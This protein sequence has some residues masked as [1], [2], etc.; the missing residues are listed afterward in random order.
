MVDPLP[1]KYGSALT[2]SDWAGLPLRIGHVPESGTTADL[3][4]DVDTVLV[5]AGGPS[6]L[7]IVYRIETTSEPLSVQFRRNPGSMDLLPRGTHLLSIDWQGQ[8]SVCTAVNF[9]EAALTALCPTH[10]GGLDKERG[11]RFGL[12]DAHVFDLVQR[13][14]TQA[15]GPEFF[16]ALYVQSL[17]LALASYLTA[18]YGKQA[19]DETLSGKSHLS[20]EQRKKVEEFV[21]RELPCNFGLVD[22][23]SLTGYSP[24]HFSRLFKQSF[25]QSPHQYVLS[26]RIERAK[27]MLLNETQSIAEI[28]LV[29]GFASQAHMTSAFKRYTGTTPGA[30][31]K[32]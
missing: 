5:W 25:E 7:S 8:P 29:C 28:A 16:G 22:I 14:Q 26:R 23:A 12:V 24:D 20:Q 32:S 10:A 1:S 17:S 15:Q 3:H 30:F 11:P 19:A 6:E 4:T 21:E 13:L 18:R 27:T 2:G 31:R 9:P